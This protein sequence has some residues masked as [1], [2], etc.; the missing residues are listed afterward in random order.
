MRKLPIIAAGVGVVL[1]VG[2]GFAKWTVADHLV[3]LPDDTDITRTFAGT[4]TTLLNP[5][6][7][8]SGNTSVAVLHNVPIV[9]THRSKV[10]ESTSAS[11][12]LADTHSLSAAG[13]PVSSSTYNYAIDRTDMGRGSG[14]PQATPQDGLTFNFPIHTAKHDYTGWISDTSKSTLLTYAGTA[15][16]GGEDVYVFKTSAPAAPITDKQQLSTLPT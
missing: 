8:A 3:K 7:L 16:R 12:L 15:K 9:A 13:A 14:Y 4:A 11:S 5:S 1:I 2:A 6:A 10:L